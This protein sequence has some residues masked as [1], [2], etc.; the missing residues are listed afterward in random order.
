MRSIYSLKFVGHDGH[1]NG[2]LSQRRRSHA[3]DMLY[4]NARVVCSILNRMG[5]NSEG[6]ALRFTRR[7]VVVKPGVNRGNSVNKREAPSRR[8]TTCES[9]PN[10]SGLAGAGIFLALLEST[11][12]SRH[13]IDLSGGSTAP[14]INRT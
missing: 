4:I 8:A 5:N 11:V 10:Q 3:L 12:P 7:S 2:H 14:I 9:A 13:A 6:F 1:I